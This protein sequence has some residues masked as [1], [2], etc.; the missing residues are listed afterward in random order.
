MADA[1]YK[2]GMLED[3]R[4]LWSRVLAVHP[5]TSP[6]PYFNIVYSSGSGQYDASLLVSCVEHFPVYEPAILLYCHIVRNWSD[7][8]DSGPVEAA[9]EDAGFVSV[10]MSESKRKHSPDVHKAM[11]LLSL[12]GSDPS[13][14]LNPR[15]RIEQI[16]MMPFLGGSP[17]RAEAMVWKLLEEYRNSTLAYDF[18]QWYFLSRGS[19]DTAL[20]LNEARPGGP[21]PLYSALDA[22]DRGNL[23]EADSFFQ[24]M[25]ND[26]E[27]AWI[28]LANLAL[29][30]YR[31][32]K[33]VDALDELIQAASMAPDTITESDIQY[34]IALILESMGSYE[35]AEGVLEYAVSLD[36]DNH[37]ARSRLE[38]YAR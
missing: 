30:H 36:P 24:Q 7:T 1:A 34:H 14:A 20:S 9:L 2:S 27:N 35:R 25:A 6:I 17:E 22:A 23:K 38:G 11:S 3:A 32:D 29:I 12:A 19:Y 31:Q 15:F 4:S 21:D 13:G 37:R 33:D 10:K 5:E 18:A 16:R 26:S 8:D 28:G